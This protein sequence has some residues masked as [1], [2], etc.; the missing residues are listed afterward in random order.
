ME[1]ISS[2]YMVTTHFFNVII[3]GTYSSVKRELK[4]YPCQFTLEKKL[5]VTVAF[6]LTL[7][8]RFYIFEGIFTII[9]TN[10]VK[11]R[12]ENLFWKSTDRKN[13]SLNRSDS[14]FLDVYMVNSVQRP[15]KKGSKT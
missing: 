9:I 8:A 7:K 10:Y 5:Y 2:F 11:Q 3:S 14:K 15:T 6:S 4:L 1:H 13:L 12:S